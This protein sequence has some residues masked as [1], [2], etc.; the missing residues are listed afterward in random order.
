MKFAIWILFIALLIA[1]ASAG[2]IP[3][4]EYLPPV[5]EE[6]Q[7]AAEQPLEESAAFAKDGYRY[8]TVRRLRHRRDVSELFPQGTLAEDGYHYHSPKPSEPLA[9]V[10]QEYLPPAAEESTE[11]KEI[12]EAPQVSNEYLPPVAEDESEKIESL[13]EAAEISKEYLPPSTEAAA[14]L[15]VPKF[16]ADEELPSPSD[17]DAVI[18]EGP[19]ESSVLADDGYHYRRIRYRRDVSAPSSSVGYSYEA[20]VDAEEIKNAYIPPAEVKDGSN[21]EETIKEYLPPVAEVK[22]ASETAALADDGYRYKTIRRLKYRQRRDV[23]EIAATT[24]ENVEESSSAVSVEYLPPVAE[25]KEVSDEPSETAELAEDGY[26]YKTIRKLKYRQRRDVSEIVAPESAI[27]DKDGYHYRVPEPTEV[28]P[29]VSNEYLPPPAKLREL[30]EEPKELETTEAPIVTESTS[31]VSEISTE[32]ASIETTEAPSSSPVPA[33]ISNEYLP[34]FEEVPL[35]KAASGDSSTTAAPTPNP[36]SISNQYL[37][38]AEELAEVKEASEINEE[39][40][41][42]ADDGYHYKVGK[43]FRF[44]RD[45]S[46]IIT[47]QNGYG[48]KAPAAETASIYLPPV[49]ATKA[50]ESNESPQVSS[51]YLPPLEDAINDAE[52][53][54]SPEESAVLADDGYHYKTVRR[55]KYRTRRDVSEIANPNGYAYPAPA[56]AQEESAVLADDGY[57]Y[58]TV[59]RLRYRHRRDVSE[60]VAPA[61]ESALLSK[62]GYHYKTPSN[63]YLPPSVE[64]VA[65]VK[66]ALSIEPPIAPD[67]SNEYLPPSEAA[68]KEASSLVVSNEYLPP[69]EVATGNPEILPQESAIL[70]DDGYHYK[71]VRRIRYRHRR[72][73]S[74]IAN[75]QADGYNYNAPVEVEPQ[76]IQYLPPPVEE[77]AQ[78][79]EAAETA[80]ES[81]TLADDGYRYKTVKRIR[82]RHRV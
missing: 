6:E 60:L 31:A 37:P 29:K 41:V 30:P 73:V 70:A 40:A 39:T 7:V 63:D 1:F 8:K 69:T 18:I 76:E 43:R 72:D 45:V 38:P 15:D 42:L 79:K 67:V 20:P 74:E 12:S 78:V 23:S 71:T 35:V 32:A 46:E 50:A 61:E 62:D 51:E 59:R 9:K 14:T 3:E 81:S 82:Y 33:A 17:D 11:N 13:G 26:R 55:L 68:P 5:E 10:A 80:A 34:P 56:A 64:D 19:E 66:E 75:Q 4:E 28:I 54:E 48:Y 25:V 27:L 24:P 21:V 44:R 36:V 52:I 58:K 47:P 16:S 49:E 65:E 77:T 53:I 22:E 2:I 57:R